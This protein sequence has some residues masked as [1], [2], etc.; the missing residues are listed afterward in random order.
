VTDYFVLLLFLF[1]FYFEIVFVPRLT[2]SQ[3]KK[4]VNSLL[5]ERGSFVGGVVRGFLFDI[6]R[7]LTLMLL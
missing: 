4:L 1:L 3:P 7:K 5:C 2:L 6:E